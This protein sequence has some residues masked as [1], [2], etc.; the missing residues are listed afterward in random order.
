MLRGRIR[1]DLVFCFCW[2]LLYPEL[3]E[4][5]AL[6]LAMHAH[7]LAPLGENV[8]FAMLLLVHEDMEAS[9]GDVDA[10]HRYPLSCS[11]L[12]YGTLWHNCIRIYI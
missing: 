5:C 4:V 1:F 6:S 8:S 2:F 11:V 7:M 12:Y 3:D 9:Q 10:L